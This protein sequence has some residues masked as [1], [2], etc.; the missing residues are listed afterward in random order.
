MLTVKG[1]LTKNYF[2]RYPAILSGIMFFS[3]ITIALL[4]AGLHYWCILPGLISM[5][6]MCSFF[7]S[8]NY[9]RKLIQWITQASEIQLLVYSSARPA[10]ELIEQ[11]LLP[12]LSKHIFVAKNVNARIT[13]NLPH[14]LYYELHHHV[15]IRELPVVFTFH[16][17]DYTLYSFREELKQLGKG[18]IEPNELLA[19][20]RTVLKE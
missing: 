8:R 11:E 10:Q 18:E 2:K 15:T 20:M 4:I 5:A 14:H 12:V 16:G 7:K 9:H 6:T 3:A 17:L 13:G 1:T 19:L